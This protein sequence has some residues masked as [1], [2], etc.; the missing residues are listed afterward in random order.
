[1]NFIF[2]SSKTSKNMNLIFWKLKKPLKTWISFLQASK[3][4]KNMNFIFCKLKK[5]QKTWISFFLRLKTSKNMNFIFCKLKYLQK[6]ELW[7][8]FFGDSSIINRE[9]QYFLISPILEIFWL[10]NIFQ[11]SLISMTRMYFAHKIWLHYSE[12]KTQYLII[13]TSLLFLDVFRLTAFFFLLTRFFG[14]FRRSG[15]FWVFFCGNE[16]FAFI[17]FFG[18]VLSRRLS[19]FSTAACFWSY[20]LIVGWW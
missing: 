20:S 17:F 9:K 10:D 11:N 19:F 7:T 3:T 15:F 18:G 13:E 12:S 8:F 16:S 14:A 6:H 1:M 2:A 4:S 5:P